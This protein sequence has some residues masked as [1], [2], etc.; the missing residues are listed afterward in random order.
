MSEYGLKIKN[1]EAG[2]IYGYQVNL[3][4]TLSVLNLITEQIHL[5]KK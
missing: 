5:K 1:F 4:E 2:S 3:Q